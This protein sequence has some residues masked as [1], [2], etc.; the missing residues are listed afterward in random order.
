MKVIVRSNA[1]T[2][3]ETL[4]ALFILSFALLALAGLME[5]TTRNNS[6][7]GHMTEAATLAQDK[8]EEFRT[9][10]FDNIQTD[11]DQKAGSHGIQY[12]RNW[13]VVTS[14]DGNLK[15]V[16]LNIGWSDKYNHSIRI[17]SAVNRRG[18]DRVEPDSV[19]MHD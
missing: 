17:T 5:T 16:T 10:P 19:Q 2:L 4:I 3:I 8:L 18:P 7:G 6:A 11:S 12:V 9:K 14:A 1:F 15:T 13:N